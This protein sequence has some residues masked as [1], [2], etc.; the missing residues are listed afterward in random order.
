MMLR[1]GICMALFAV[2]SVAVRS[3]QEVVAHVEETDDLG[4]RLKLA[5]SGTISAE[6]E[7]EAAKRQA[8]VDHSTELLT[9]YTTLAMDDH[10]V[11]SALLENGKLAE[12]VAANLQLKSTGRGKAHEQKALASLLERTKSALSQEEANRLEASLKRKDAT[13][14]ACFLAG[15]NLP[16]YPLKKVWLAHVDRACGSSGSCTSSCLNDCKR[17][18]PK[19]KL[20]VQQGQEIGAQDVTQPMVAAQCKNGVCMCLDGV[21]TTSSVVVAKLA[22]NQPNL[23]IVKELG[24]EGNYMSQQMC[25][26]NCHCTDYNGLDWEGLCLDEW[27]S[28]YRGGGGGSGYNLGGLGGGNQYGGHHW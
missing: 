23:D 3:E 1:A 18:G 11:A 25:M 27:N 2:P 7:A 19:Y 13:P 16:G 9:A 24:P 28:A 10:E 22:L 26:Q 14:C 5:L 12:A 8:L 17:M 6:E 20:D 4:Q 21:Q 15:A